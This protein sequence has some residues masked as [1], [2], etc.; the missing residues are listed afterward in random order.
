MDI[1]TADGKLQT[2]SECSNPDLFF[3]V[4]GG[5][6][7][8]WGI[9]TRVTYRTYP[10]VPLAYVFGNSTNID[11]NK[12]AAQVLVE[13]LARAAPS[14]EDKGYGGLVILTHNAFELA[15][16]I[17]NGTVDQMKARELSTLSSYSSSSFVHIT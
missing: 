9:T 2:I 13:R 11:L 6:G 14:L 5:G 4:R 7:G 10:A 3:A 8:T 17:P 15:G 16:I 1:V 12:D